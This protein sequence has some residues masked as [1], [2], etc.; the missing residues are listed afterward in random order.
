MQVHLYEVIVYVI[1][2]RLKRAKYEIFNLFCRIHSFTLTFDTSYKNINFNLIKKM[3]KKVQRKQNT[4]L[5][6]TVVRVKHKTRSRISI[7][8]SPRS[9]LKAHLEKKNK[10]IKHS[11]VKNC[12]Y[13]KYL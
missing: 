2:I 1:L 6:F 4:F 13:N 8:Q 10:H 9:N 7:T 11:V 3:K 12:I 5:G